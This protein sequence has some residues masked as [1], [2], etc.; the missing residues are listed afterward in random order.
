MF[1]K[2]H[3][4]RLLA[5]ALVFLS[6]F[7][8][9]TKI[10]A[11][12]KEPND[13]KSLLDMSIEDLMDVQ[14]VTASRKPQSINASPADISVITEKEILDSGAQ[15][16]AKL[17]KRL[18][19]VYVPTQGHGEESIYIRGIGERYNDKT[20]LMIDGYP[21]RDVY[22]YTFPLNGTI[23]LANIKRIEVVKG[24]GS[25]LYGSNAFAGVINIITKDPQDIKET[26][27]LS[28]IGS[29]GTK[30]HHVLWA[31]HGEDGGVSI[32]ARYLDADLD[33]VSN[34]EDGVRSGQNRF[35]R[36]E[37]MHLK[38]NYR[39][40]DFQVGYYR[41]ELPD[42]MESISDKEEETQE[43]TFFRLG[44]TKDLTDRLDM[45]A[46]AYFNQFQTEGAKLSFNG[47]TLDKR[48][49]TS[50]KSDIGGLDVQWR[51]RLSPR[52][53]LLFGAS[54]EHE[55]LDHSW[56]REFDPP[57]AAPTLTGW[58]SSSQQSVP[59]VTKGNNIGIYAEDEIKLI[60]DHLNLTI[61]ARFDDYEHTGSRVSPRL[62][63]V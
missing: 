23:P 24:P 44:Y 34:D 8:A 35:L 9:N 59:T 6:L 63:V 61:G 21:F 3:S 39:D 58:A 20:L 4:V 42:F 11:E 17:L 50:R 48:K 40:M 47:G 12:Q 41:T 51:Y 57:T 38:G 60:P 7:T 56:S 5:F 22:Y 45:R 18:P 14:V 54:Y 27:V 28:G 33:H 19:G 30:Q 46:R 1:P 36:N 55:R 31:T 32:L 13:Q 2:N 29:R 62:G 37:A 10:C 43:Y 53:E 52:N 16:L 49:E 25:S 15:T 26:E